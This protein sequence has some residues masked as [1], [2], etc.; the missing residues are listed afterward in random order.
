MFFHLLLYL[1][2]TCTGPIPH[3]SPDLAFSETVRKIKLKKEETCL[4]ISPVQSPRPCRG[5]PAEPSEF[6][7][8]KIN[9]RESVM[10]KTAEK[11]KSRLSFSSLMEPQVFWKKKKG[12]L[13]RV[14]FNFR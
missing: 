9:K 2:C 4:Q 8:G 10:F 3:V 12:S 1:I 14:R 13:Q 11:Y 6:K 7:K 5:L